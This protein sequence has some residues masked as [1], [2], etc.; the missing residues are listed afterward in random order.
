MRQPVRPGVHAF[1]ELDRRDGLPRRARDPQLLDVRQR[2]RPP[3]PPVRVRRVVEPARRTC[4]WSRPGRRTARRPATRR[5]A[6]RTSPR[7]SSTRRRAA[8]PT[9]PDYAWT[10]LTYLL[11]RATSAGATTSPRAP[12]LIAGT[13]PRRAL[14]GRRR[15]GD[16]ADLEPAALLRHRPR[17]TVRSATSRPSRTSSPTRGPEPCPTSHGSSPTARRASIRRR[18]SA[19]ARRYVTR[20]INAVM[21]VPDWP[22]T[23]IFLAWDDWGGF[24]DHVAPP[25]GRRERLRPARARDWSSART[26]GTG[27]IDH[28]TL[29]FDAY[30]KFIED[31]FLGRP[32][33]RSRHR[34]TARPAAGRSGERPILGDLVADFDFSQPPRAPVLLP[35]HPTPGPAPSG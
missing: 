24:Y 15:M 5:A 19:P 22:R 7:T 4:T 2:F 1:V 34:W 8:A 11:H 21:R 12:S 30:L 33:P 31:D 16:A 28:Q 14:R 26:R 20:L 23:A 17:R 32:A 10:D 3:G 13:T 25:Q 27:Y 9:R 18:W 35:L 6:S 29:S